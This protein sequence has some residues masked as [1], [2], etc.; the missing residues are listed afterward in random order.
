LSSAS[1]IIASR[2]AIEWLNGFSDPATAQLHG[3]NAVFGAD[4]DG[5][6]GDFLI[7][8]GVD[9][10]TNAY[11]IQLVNGE[12]F[13]PAYPSLSLANILNPD[14]FPTGL[15]SGQTVSVFDFELL[16]PF[17]LEITTITDNVQGIV[18]MEG[19]MSTDNWKVN[20]T[21]KIATDYLM[22]N[23]SNKY[24]FFSPCD[25]SLPS[26]CD[27]PTTDSTIALNDTIGF[28]AGTGLI[29]SVQ[30]CMIYS[31]TSGSPTYPFSAPGLAA[32]AQY[33]SIR[34]IVSYQL[35]QDQAN[36]FDKQFQAVAS[37]AQAVL[38]A[39]V[40]IG[41]LFFIAGA[42]FLVFWFIRRHRKLSEKAEM[43]LVEDPFNEKNKNI[44]K[45]KY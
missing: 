22:P 28:D 29:A 34:R 33:S 16:R 21:L 17:N 18:A 27:F 30:K 14:G 26:S 13:N 2:T 31:F 12:L 40:I 39:L 35:S 32:N 6:I 15:A 37:T 11:K 41:G 43:D 38:L 1:G 19:L 3:S 25:V 7:N 36:A 44:A 10:T 42:T 8:I 23:P 4:A 9:S 5:I 45:M 24:V 20:S